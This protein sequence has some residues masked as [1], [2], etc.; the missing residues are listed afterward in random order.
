MPVPAAVPR[1]GGL[2][3]EHG[4]ERKGETAQIAGETTELST[5]AQAGGAVF[6]P[7]AAGGGRRP[8]ASRRSGAD[9]EMQ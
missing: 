7:G 3:G 1:A 2:W 6:F 5:G 9:V 4:F 8:N